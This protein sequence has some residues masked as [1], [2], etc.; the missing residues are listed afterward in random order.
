MGTI[1]DLQKRQQNG[2]C[3][4]YQKQ[5]Y[6][7]SAADGVSSHSDYLDILEQSMPL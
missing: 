1:V 7:S 4:Y 3:R 5:D 2:P 6:S